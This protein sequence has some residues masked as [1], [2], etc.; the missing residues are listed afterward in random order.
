LLHARKNMHNHVPGSFADLKFMSFSGKL[1]NNMKEFLQRGFWR[2]EIRTCLLQEMDERVEQRDK[3][4]HYDDVYNIW[5]SVAKSMFKFN[6]NE[7]KSLKQWE[8]KLIEKQF[9]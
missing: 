4:F 7:F 5:L 3:M 6:E 1:K 9:K 8:E 2:R